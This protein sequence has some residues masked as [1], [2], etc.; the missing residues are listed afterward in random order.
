MPDLGERGDES[1]SVGTRS[2][3]SIAVP[4]DGVDR[5]QRAGRGFESI[6]GIGDLALVRHRHREAGDPQHAHRIER[7]A[8][9]PVGHIERDVGPVDPC[10]VEG[11]L[12]D[13]R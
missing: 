4:A 10:R 11:G 12:V 6:D 1:R 5:L 9:S 3:E 7:S 2:D 8:T 13:D